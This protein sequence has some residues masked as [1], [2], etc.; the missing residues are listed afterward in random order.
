LVL[1]ERSRDEDRPLTLGLIADREYELV[2][3]RLTP[4]ERLVLLYDGVPERAQ[5][6]ASYGIDRLA[7][8]V[9]MPAQVIADA[10]GSSARKTTSSF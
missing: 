3:G 4:E 2:H 1:P 7:S 6:V 9:L 10:I 8:L 5:P